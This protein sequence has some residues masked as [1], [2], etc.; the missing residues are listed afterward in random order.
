MVGNLPVRASLWL[1]AYADALARVSGPTAL[2]RLDGHAPRIQVLRA[3]HVNALAEVGGVD[4]PLGDAIADIARQVSTWVVRAGG[5]VPIHS[6]LDAQPDRITILCGGDEP[7][8]VGV[9]R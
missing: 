1:T 5:H 8:K 7:A 9:M 3:A 2:I 6:M 4:S